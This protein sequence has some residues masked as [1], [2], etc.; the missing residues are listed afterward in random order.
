MGTLPTPFGVNLK[1]PAGMMRIVNRFV[2]ISIISSIIAPCGVIYHLFKAAQIK[3]QAV[4]EFNSTLKRFLNYIVEYHLEAAAHDL[5]SFGFGC[6]LPIMALASLYFGYGDFC[7]GISH[8]FLDQ[9]I[10]GIALLCFATYGII[11]S[12]QLLGVINIRNAALS[13]D[14]NASRIS[15]WFWK[16]LK[17]GIII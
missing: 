10:Q 3:L 2:C 11:E 17:T 14:Q 7:F 13:I 5:V 12:Q 6:I 4:N 9:T 15:D 1:F 16:F 8:N